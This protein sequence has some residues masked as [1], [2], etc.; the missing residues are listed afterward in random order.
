M[1]TYK[2]TGNLNIYSSD[3]NKLVAGSDTA[4][5]FQTFE[6]LSSWREIFIPESEVLVIGVFDNQELMGL[7]VLRKQADKGTFLGTDRIGPGADLV[8]DFGDI[9]AKKGCE[10][11]IW[12]KV[13]LAAKEIGIKELTLDYVRETSPS[14]KLL[15]Q[16][17]LPYKEMLDAATPDV[18]PYLNLPSRFD[19]YLN[20]LGRKQR[21]E[22]RRKLR[23]L[24]RKEYK[25]IISREPNDITEFI[26]LHKASTTQK[27]RFMSSQM[28]N[29]FTTVVNKLW[30]QGLIDLVFIEIAGKKVSSTLSFLWPSFA[31]ASE[32]KNKEYWLYNSG[33]DRSYQDLAIGFLLKGLT[34][35]R[36][37]ELGYNR[38]SFLRGGE[39]YK[40]DLGAKDEKLYKIIIQF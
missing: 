2:I 1:L 8:T 14:F 30:P 25:I 33:F 37:I 17:G 29:F 16:L 10:K 13:I 35:K 4:T 23:R 26:R 36:A 27:D 6:Y 22:W 9:V 15:T 12:E 24:E 40:Y 5:V 39:R 18:A 32:G 34:I 20:S 11:E 28:E 38:Y 7:A 3:W 31:E 19:D 21:H